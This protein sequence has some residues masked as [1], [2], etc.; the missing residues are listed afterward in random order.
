AAD[1]REGAGSDRFG[2]IDLGDEEFGEASGTIG[3]GESDVEEL[4]FSDLPPEALDGEAGNVE[5]PADAAVPGDAAA[6]RATKAKR[7][8]KATQI[9]IAAAAAA[10][11]ALL[12]GGGY[13]LKNTAYGAFGI[14]AVE[15]LLPASGDDGQLAEVIARAESTASADTYAAARR[16]LATLGEARFDASL[17]RGLMTRS[18]LHEA[19]FQVRFGPNARAEARESAILQK[20]AQRSNDAPEMELALAASALRAGNLAEAKRQVVRARQADP[21]DPYVALVAGELALV[22]GDTEAARRAFEAATAAGARALWGQ[23]RA[24]LLAG[25][26]SAATAAIAETLAASPGHAA[27]R[28][29]KAR[30]ARDADDPETALNLAGEAAGTESVEGLG[31]LRAAPT[32]R[33]EA[34]TLVGEILL[35]RGRRLDAG[36]AFADAVEANPFAFRALL[37]LGQV[38]LVERR[39]TDALARF[40]SASGA[41]A[42]APEPRAGEAPN[43]V[44]VGLGQM[45]ALLNLEQRQRASQLSAE[46]AERFPDEPTVALWNGRAFEAIEDVEGAMGEFQRSVTLDPGAFDGYLAQAM[47]HFGAGDLDAA[48]AVLA[49]ARSKVRMSAKVRRQLGELELRRGN[50]DAAETELREA[51]RLNANDPV[52][53][54]ALGQVLRRKGALDETRRL[55]DTLAEADPSYPGLALERGR[56]FEAQGEASRAVDAYL[57]AAEQAPNDY[58]LLLRLGGAQ[59]AAGNLAAAE[60][61]L[62]RVQR[63]R[64]ESAEAEY[65]MGRVAFA[66][67]ESQTAL[68]RLSRAVSLD[69]RVGEYHLYLALCLLERNDIGRARGEVDEALELD[70]SLALGFRT[71]G[72]IRLR[73]GQRNDAIGDFRQSLT[74]NPGQGRAHAGIGQALEDLQQGAAAIDEYEQAV[75]LDA[76]KGLWWYRL[77]RARLDAGRTADAI[78]AL[79]RANELG[80]DVSVEDDEAPPT[81]VFDAHRIRADALRLSQRRDEALTH[82]RRYLELAPPTALDREAVQNAIDEITR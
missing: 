18:V 23:A 71:R 72:E 1:G 53:R 2:E 70:D 47:V 22:E 19:L 79:A 4:D 49:E 82:Y 24:A 44:R 68:T 67:G 33:A 62:E 6:A 10:A 21:E 8:A 7:Q 12:L 38:L 80:D 26:E 76:T 45:E 27:A 54:F 50:L 39:F 20:L 34:L 66:R 59:L 15:G 36:R 64:P 16:S 5:I 69:P 40:E 73:L 55:F 56:L 17:N 32:E 30:A 14:Y 46:L 78:T 65:F 9:K 81:W 61:T 37:G 63:E 43:E 28:V 51:V 25:N 41:L 58:D 52:A 3:A 11:V 48:G 75:R 31:A 57:R 29:A 77:G 60:E 35:E 42:E 13:A 74:L